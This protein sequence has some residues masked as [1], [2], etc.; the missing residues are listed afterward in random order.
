MNVSLDKLITLLKREGVD[1][2]KFIEELTKKEEVGN[3]QVLNSQNSLT[4]EGF[5]PVEHA[6]LF[7]LPIENFEE[8]IKFI[9]E[10]YKKVELKEAWKIFSILK[11][12]TF[13]KRANLAKREFELLHQLFEPISQ[14]LTALIFGLDG[15]PSLIVNPRNK[16]TK[17]RINARS[18]EG[19]VALGLAIA[20]GYE[21]ERIRA[22]ILKYYENPDFGTKTLANCLK[23]DAWKPIY[24]SM[25]YAKEETTAIKNKSYHKE[26]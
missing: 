7:A 21:P 2:E 1:A 15:V 17:F 8:K 23:E 18:K 24:E 22:S 20:N 12:F 10:N 14:Q 13:S 26:I 25:D 5:I 9:K 11:G 19:T 4:E 6:L 3:L 16:A